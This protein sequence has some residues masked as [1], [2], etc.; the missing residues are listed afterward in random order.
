[1]DVDS[2]P[3]AKGKPTQIDLEDQASMHLQV[4]V[5]DRLQECSEFVE[6]SAPQLTIM[7]EAAT[8]ARQEDVVQFIGWSF[9]LWCFC[10]PWQG[11]QDG[12]RLQLASGDGDEIRNLLLV[13]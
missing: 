3:A 6:F 10:L 4:S 8:P 5:I 9:L 2:D 11:Q 7:G 13:S 1:M 12:M